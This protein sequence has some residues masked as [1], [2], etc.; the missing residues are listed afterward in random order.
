LP[1]APPARDVA[2]EAV[3]EIRERLLLEDHPVVLAVGRFIPRKGHLRLVRALARV[4]EQVPNVHLV[5]VGRGPTRDACLEAAKEM[6]MGAFVHCPG[7]LDDGDVAALYHTCT[8]FAL[9]N[10]EDG[11][12]QVEGFGLVFAE[13]GAYGKPVVAGRSGGATDAVVDAETGILVDPED[14]DAI[15]DAI[16][17]I[18]THPERAR[19]MGEAGRRRVESELNWDAFATGVL[20]AAGVAE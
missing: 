3:T 19:T 9:P 12:G 8:L 17:A 11:R 20:R 14:L 10:G 1:G 7:Y 5:M 16:I 6:G 18:L 13:A 15:A 4:H 2:R